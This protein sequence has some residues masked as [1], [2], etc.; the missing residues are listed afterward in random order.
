MIRTVFFAFIGSLFLLSCSKKD[1]TT[2][3][4][5]I[6]SSQTTQNNKA[7]MW[8]Q[9]PTWNFSS[10]TGGSTFQCFDAKGTNQN[11]LGFAVN[12]LANKAV[13]VQMYLHTSGTCAY[14]NAIQPEII[15]HALPA[16]T[17]KTLFFNVSGQPTNITKVMVKITPQTLTGYSG[18]AVATYQTQ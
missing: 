9:H 11:A 4:E 13:I 16:N 15:Y 3:V 7:S 14:F 8:S 1:T 2:Q 6:P 18:S 12:V 17:S 10:T 5:P